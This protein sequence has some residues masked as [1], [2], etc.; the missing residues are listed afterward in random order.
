MRPGTALAV[1]EYDRKL[2]TAFDQSYSGV[3]IG[4]RDKQAADDYS[5]G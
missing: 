3:S 1:V 2:C 5:F 4:S